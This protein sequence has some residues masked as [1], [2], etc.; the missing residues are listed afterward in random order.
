MGS[1]PASPRLRPTGSSLGDEEEDENE[2]VRVGRGTAPGT[3][4]PGKGMVLGQRIRNLESK[5]PVSA[6]LGG[7]DGRHGMVCDR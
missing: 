4:I 5:D 6:D 2:I 1:T 7:E 3:P